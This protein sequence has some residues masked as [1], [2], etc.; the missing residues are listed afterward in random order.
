M[1][2]K[3]CAKEK[4]E[5]DFYQSNK[6]K[7]KECIK[8]AS[9]KNRLENID[10]FR[11]YDK[12]RASMPHRVQARTEYQKT[13]RF[14]ESHAKAITKNRALFKVR[15]NARNLVAKAVKSGKLKKQPCFICGSEIVEAHH[16]DYNR[17]LDVIWLCNKHHR[18]AHDLVKSV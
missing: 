6:S 2:C 4:C 11:A 17:P 12:L 18:E 10:R 16:P 13:D 15:A 9:K 1:K 7:C 3:S 5:G 14:K 8:V